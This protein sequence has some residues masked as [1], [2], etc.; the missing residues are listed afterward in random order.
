MED[1]AF[2]LIDGFVWVPTFALIGTRDGH[3]V[4][5]RAEARR[6]CR[7]FSCG[8]F[9]A[10]GGCGGGCIA[11]FLFDVALDDGEMIPTRNRSAVDVKMAHTHL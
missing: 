4:G 1:A 10:D 3:R 7:R 2:E 5:E 6:R 11:E 8:D 9:F